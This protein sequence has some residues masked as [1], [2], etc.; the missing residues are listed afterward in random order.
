[1]AGAWRNYLNELLAPQLKI[2]E[3]AQESEKKNV[4]KTLVS[5]A[6]QVSTRDPGE[7]SI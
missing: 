6:Y 4:Q 3:S 5:S 2:S 7:L 1:L